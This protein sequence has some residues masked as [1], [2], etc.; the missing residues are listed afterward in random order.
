MFIKSHSM[1]SIRQLGRGEPE[2]VVAC[3]FSINQKFT[4]DHVVGI[5]WQ[6]FGCIRLVV[7][8][9]KLHIFRLHLCKVTKCF[10]FHSTGEIFMFWLFSLKKNK[11]AK[12][13]RRKFIEKMSRWSRQFM[14]QG[15]FSAVRNVALN[16]SFVHRQMFV[17]RPDDQTQCSL[18][19]MSR[20]HFSTTC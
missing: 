20:K 6:L 13:R 10:R 16:L 2:F 3:L 4:L 5:W 14:G 12:N 9:L 1:T 18:C 8:S 7:G 11:H 19:V 17:K 15:A